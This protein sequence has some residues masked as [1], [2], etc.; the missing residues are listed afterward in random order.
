MSSFDD[1]DSAVA[2]AHLTIRRADIVLRRTAHML[3][4][5]LEIARVP[6]AVL[7]DLKKELRRYDMRTGQWKD[8]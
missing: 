6:D 2:E 7:A 3:R 8:E 4:G 1:M 5:R